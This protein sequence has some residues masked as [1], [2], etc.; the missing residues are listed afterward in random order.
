MVGIIAT[1]WLITADTVGIHHPDC[2][3]LANL[4]SNAVDYPK[5]GNPVN[6]K[7]LPR[8]PRKQKP[9][10]SAPETYIFESDESDEPQYYESQRA[11]GK[12]F[13][14]IKFP[15]DTR[16]L[17]GTTRIY[18]LSIQRRQDTLRRTALSPIYRALLPKIRDFVRVDEIDEELD[19]VSD[20]LFARYKTELQGIC[21][22][23][24]LSF[25]KD[26]SLT[27]E[28]VVIGT[29]VQKT[30]SPQRRKYMISVLRDNTDILVPGIREVLEFKN[31]PDDR[32]VD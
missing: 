31:G 25:A 28:E 21:I 16:T 30:S 20:H 10:W 2:I 24:S 14:A 7:E 22:T 29:I 4:H 6:R 17:E 1:N 18:S 5:S 27:E 26:A 13:R 11:I 12:L 3:K 23:R 32:G 8:L 9:D 19:S 15:P